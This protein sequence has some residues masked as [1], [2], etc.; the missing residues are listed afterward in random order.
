MIYMLLCD[1]VF[2]NCSARNEFISISTQI[3]NDV[4]E[5]DNLLY[6][7]IVISSQNME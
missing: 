3:D 4:S 2:S 7:S 6:S 5:Y 1:F